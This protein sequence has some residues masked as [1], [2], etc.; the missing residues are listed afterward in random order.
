MP[1]ESTI[2]RFRHL[3]EKLRVAAQILALINDMLGDKSPM[4]HAGTVM[5]APLIA[6]A[7]SI[8]NAE[9]ERGPEMH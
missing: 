1:D 9:G 7:S 4:L 2:L 5:D 6:A 8:E 3:L